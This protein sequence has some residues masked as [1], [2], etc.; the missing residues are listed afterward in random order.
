MKFR[1]DAWSEFEYISINIRKLIVQVKNIIVYSQNILNK[2][3][4]SFSAIE[5]MTC[6]K[7]TDEFV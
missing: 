6:N 3:S 2:C 7:K 4:S 1:L 5:L